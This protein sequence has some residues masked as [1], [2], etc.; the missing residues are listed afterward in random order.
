MDKKILLAGLHNTGKTTYIAALSYMLSNFDE[1]FPFRLG[2]LENGEDEYLSIIANA[3]M[4]L[5]PVPRT[6]HTKLQGESVSINVINNSD[7]EKFSL[8]IPDFSGE[9]FRRQFEN[10][11]WDQEFE[12]TVRGL[13]GMMLFINPT[14]V[15]NRPK[16]LIARNEAEQA[17]GIF[18]TNHGV[19]FKPY[20]TEDTCNQ[21]KLAD[22][23]QFITQYASTRFPIKL[24]VVVSMWDQVQTLGEESSPT[25]WI[26]YQTPL[27]YQYLSCNS[28]YFCTKFFGISSQGGD[29]EEREKIVELDSMKRVLV[30]DDFSASNDITQPIVWITNDN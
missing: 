20:S 6:N 12:E 25:D 3:W 22:C 7:G 23:L 28:E 8:Q 30:V 14:D 1:S 11:E 17:L 2:S 18:N 19:E 15:N 13:S 21:V 5:E 24:A 29:Y 4:R 10:R 9:T 16:L 26:K 27:L